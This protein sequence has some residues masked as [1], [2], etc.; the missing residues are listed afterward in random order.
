MEMCYVSKGI[1]NYIQ[2]ST[3]NGVVERNSPVAY[4]LK[5][6]EK[7]DIDGLIRPVVMEMDGTLTLKYNTSSY[8][9]LDRLFLKLK[10]DGSF[11]GIIMEQLERLMYKLKEFLLEPD[12]LVIKPEY[13]FYNWGE[14]AL[15]LVYI[16]G[17]G[18]NIKH[19]LK[20]FLEYI[21][22]IFDH[23]DESGVRYMYGIYDLISED[24]FSI[25]DFGY[26]LGAGGTVAEYGQSVACGQNVN[27]G[28]S[29]ACE[30]SANYGQ[31]VDYERN[32]AGEQNVDYGQNVAGGQN[33]VPAEKE[34]TKLVPLTSGALKEIVISKYD[35]MILVGR[36]KRETDYRIPTTQISRVHACIYIRSNGLYV[37]DREST[38]GTFINSVRLEPLKQER[39]VVGDLI[40]FANEEF[41][42][43]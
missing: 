41:F 27:Y 31:S 18:K 12:D 3:A 34:V 20:S 4:R 13:M 19:Q 9:V 39:I 40:N 15:K 32:L 17:Y 38:N 30:P 33:A 36:G 2:V 14:K 26:R 24:T 8:Y 7:N 22:R 11:L 16:P 35:E 29:I 6:L 28:Q 5:M 25:S 43:V 42:A 37:E 23:R 10:P 21:M 1:N